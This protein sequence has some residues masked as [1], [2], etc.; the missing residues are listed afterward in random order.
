[1]K[2]QY[3]TMATASRSD[4]SNKIRRRGSATDDCCLLSDLPSRILEHTATFLAPPSRALFALAL[5]LN[6]A[7][8]PNE[9]SSAIAG[10]QW[11]ILDFGGVEKELASKLTDDNIQAVLSC[12]DA[13]N[14]VKILKLTNCVSVTGAGLN[15]LRGSLL[16]EQI[17]LSL[18]GD[19]ESPKLNPEPPISKDHVIPILDSIIER[20]GCALKLIQFPKVMRKERSAESDFHHFIQRYKEILESR[21]MCCVECKETLSENA[22]NTGHY[23]LKHYALQNNICY[24]C[25]KHYCSGRVNEDECSYLRHCSTCERK[26][27]VRCVPMLSCE[28]CGDHCPN[29]RSFMACCTPGCE[30]KDSCT[31]CVEKCSKCD[32][33]W[34][35]D[36]RELRECENCNILCC[37]ECFREEG[38]VL[39]CENSECY[40]PLCNDCRILEC[41][42]GKGNCPSC[43]SMAFAVLSER[44]QELKREVDQLMDENKDLKDEVKRLRTK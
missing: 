36:C 13:V 1:M 37:M 39:C 19:C 42:E 7:K 29:C 31:E 2:A 26:Y 43:V 3:K 25:M 35:E 22:I 6:S 41:Q 11:D 8:L 33:N 5:D 34:C 21:G 23:Y 40:K 14:R 9:R 15:P 28:N 38:I 18:V 16:I 10:N 4:D 30:M 24:G 32:R 20:E 44:A 12:I 27:C 17:D